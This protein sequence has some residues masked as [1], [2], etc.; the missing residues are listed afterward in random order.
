M[1]AGCLGGRETYHAAGTR[2]ELRMRVR[3]LFFSKHVGIIIT[4]AAFVQ[5]CRLAVLIHRN[6]RPV[7]SGVGKFL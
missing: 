1:V 7:E 5:R 3:K 4:G 2:P 6:R